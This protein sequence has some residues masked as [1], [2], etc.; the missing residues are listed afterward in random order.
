MS[1]MATSSVKP[2]PERSDATAGS[3]MD[4]DESSTEVASILSRLRSPPPSDLSRKIKIS[5]N[6]PKGTKKGK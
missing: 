1:E 4:T 5:S 2:N 6:P 3:S